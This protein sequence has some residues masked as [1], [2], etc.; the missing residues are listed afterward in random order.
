MVCCSPLLK[1][2]CTFRVERRTT[3]TNTGIRICTSIAKWSTDG[4]RGDDLSP[5]TH[6][7]AVT[8]AARICHGPAGALFGATIGRNLYV[9][10]KMRPWREEMGR[11]EPGTVLGNNASSRLLGTAPLRRCHSKSAVRRSG[12]GRCG[13]VEFFRGERGAASSSAIIYFITTARCRQRRESEKGGSIAGS[14]RAATRNTTACRSG[15]AAAEVQRRIESFVS[16]AP[17]PKLGGR[18]KRALA[19]TDGPHPE[20]GPPPAGTSLSRRG[21]LSQVRSTSFCR[22]ETA[23]NGR[24]APTTDL[25]TEYDGRQ[26]VA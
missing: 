5:R 23:A 2:Y 20:G 8:F 14:S 21:G 9:G 3:Q 4:A 13:R 6:W 18:K 15:T 24:W 22:L 11:N 1:H 7:P 26:F 12:R 16:G 17:M 19:A 10:A 25:P